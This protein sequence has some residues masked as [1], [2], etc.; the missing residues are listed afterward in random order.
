MIKNHF[1]F[2]LNGSEITRY[3]MMFFRYG[4]IDSKNN[5]DGT[6]YTYREMY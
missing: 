3:A 2:G 6:Y 1:C 5:I 4:I